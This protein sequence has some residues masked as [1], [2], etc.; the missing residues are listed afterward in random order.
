MT[1]K[2]PLGVFFAD[3]Q[4]HIESLNRSQSATTGEGLRTITEGFPF[5]D[6]APPHVV[7]LTSGSRENP[8]MVLGT[9]LG[10]IHWEDCPSDV[11]S[12]HLLQK[13]ITTR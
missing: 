2:A 5:C 10:I 13:S 7:G 3:W 4:H 12:E 6:V 11:E 9:K 1:P 8:I